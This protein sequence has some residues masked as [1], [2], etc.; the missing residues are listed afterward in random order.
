MQ[1]MPL[2]DLQNMVLG[3][4]SG[5][6]QHVAVR[7]QAPV[8]KHRGVGRF[9][10]NQ[11]ST[12]CDKTGRSARRV[13]LAEPLGDGL[14]VC[15]QACGHL[16]GHPLHATQVSAGTPAPLAAG[17]FQPIDVDPDRHPEHPGPPASPC[18]TVAQHVDQVVATARIPQAGTV[19]GQHRCSPPAGPTPRAD[20]HPLVDGVGDRLIAALRIDRDLVPAQCQAGCQLLRKRLKPAIACGYA[21][22]AQNGDPKRGG[23]PIGAAC[24]GRP[25][26]RSAQRSASASQRPAWSFADSWMAAS[27]EGQAMAS[28]GSSQRMQRSCSGL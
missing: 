13:V 8:G 20:P 10:R 15:N 14:G 11:L 12:I 9:G 16:G 25:H 17:P 24:L 26:R 18:G 27:T 21:P 6:H 23:S 22:R 7:L 5:H 3:L 1:Q 28:C 4:R 2:D 19:I